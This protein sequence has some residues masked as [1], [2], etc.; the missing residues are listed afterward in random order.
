MLL[1]SNLAEFFYVLALNAQ[2]P[3]NH[4][5]RPDKLCDHQAIL[6]YLNYQA[7]LSLR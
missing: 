3:L 7:T 5:Q 6:S 2:S 1:F 4:H